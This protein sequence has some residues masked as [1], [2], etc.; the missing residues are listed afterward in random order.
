[1]L[2]PY[3]RDAD[4][5][6]LNLTSRFAA[7]Q[8]TLSGTGFIKASGTNITYDNSSYLRTSLADSS[9]LK[10]TGGTLTGALNGTTG[11]FSNSITSSNSINLK[12]SEP[13][14][15]LSIEAAPTIGSSN[16]KI[17][18]LNTTGLSFET[19]GV[20]RFRIQSDGTPIFYNNTFFLEYAIFSKGILDTFILFNN[21]AFATLQIIQAPT[22]GSSNNKISTVNTTGLVFETGGSERFKIESDGTSIFSSQVKINNSNTVFNEDSGDF[23]TRIESDGNAN[24]VFVDASTDRVGIG[25]ASPTKTLD[26]NGEV[27]INTVTATPTSLLGKDGSNVVGEVTTVAQTGLMTRGE[28]TATTGSPSATFTVTHGLGSTPTSVLVTSAGIAGA[29]KIIFEVYSKNSTTF[30]VQAWNYDGTEASS[31]SVKIF[32]LAIK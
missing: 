23:D 19:S 16:N 12:N 10:L 17:S 13:F 6:Q 21:D 30:S 29:E 5:T 24:M 9:Y 11:T 1:M 18:A 27:R 22:I 25:Y 26:V 31:K 3:F 32:W 20:E 28:T 15:V 4:T 2:L 8:N 7:K 14:N